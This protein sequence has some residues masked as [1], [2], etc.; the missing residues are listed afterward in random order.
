MKPWNALLAESRVAP[1]STT[2]LPNRPKMA[3]TNN[4]TSSPR[5]N[6]CPEGV[7]RRPTS[8]PKVWQS[9]M[10]KILQRI[11]HYLEPNKSKL[12]H[13]LK[14][15]AHAECQDA[16][17]GCNTDDGV[18][19]AL[20]RRAE[21]M[22]WKLDDTILTRI[23]LL[24]PLQTGKLRSTEQA[25]MPKES[26][27]A[28]TPDLAYLL[29]HIKLLDTLYA[30][31]FEA[32]ERGGNLESLVSQ[33]RIELDKERSTM[34]SLE[35]T[36]IRELKR[37]EFL[38]ATI[39]ENRA[40]REALVLEIDELQ[41][42]LLVEKIS[43]RR[44][45]NSAKGVEE[46]ARELIES[47]RADK[48][49]LEAQA[50]NALRTADIMAA[51]LT[52]L[53][54]ECDRQ[55]LLRER[56]D[57][58]VRGANMRM[59]VA[60]K[61]LIHDEHHQEEF[62]RTLAKLSE[63]RAQ[64][65]ALTSQKAEDEGN[66]HLEQRMRVQAE[67]RAN[68]HVNEFASMQS[69]A[70]SERNDAEKL[71]GEIVTLRLDLARAKRSLRDRD[72]VQRNIRTAGELDRVMNEEM[73]QMLERLVQKLAQ[74]SDD[75]NKKT[76]QHQQEIS[77][78]ELDA[79]NSP[80]CQVKQTQRGRR[81][82]QSAA[83]SPAPIGSTLALDKNTVPNMGFAALMPEADAMEGTE[84]TAKHWAVRQLILDETGPTATSKIKWDFRARRSQLPSKSHLDNLPCAKPRVLMPQM[85][86]IVDSS[87]F[88]ATV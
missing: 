44:Q 36:Y 23:A 15:R 82:G 60:Q 59:E 66:F 35:R 9:L 20:R 78:M 74:A 72:I 27:A 63:A 73:D 64:I 71:R 24:P 1:A 83:P 7:N 40:D 4:I 67:I 84:R 86:K 54:T 32:V 28:G 75:A 17:L 79:S 31:D 37:T 10:S 16:I 14:S 65:S 19:L 47:L 85:G 8:I 53:H 76:I 12:S 55:Q 50:R 25:W 68:K 88:E 87:G 2:A 77:R 34:E 52:S 62:E 6:R 21:R 5:Q 51:S 46:S 43:T 58:E 39:E 49:R 42:Q 80:K 29:V 26:V 33:L 41:R 38:E 61:A 11:D 81:S 18:I 70:E 69:Y 56:A 22:L 57:N 48:K 45:V 30:V 3:P 13:D